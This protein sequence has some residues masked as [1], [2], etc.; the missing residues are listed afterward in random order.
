L[1]RAVELHPDNAAANA[2]LGTVLAPSSRNS[3]SCRPANGTFATRSMSVVRTVR[4]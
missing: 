3:T 2:H 1:R 4:C